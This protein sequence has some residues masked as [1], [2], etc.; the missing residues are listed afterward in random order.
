ME[1]QTQYM[2]RVQTIRTE[3]YSANQMASRDRKLDI[4]YKKLKEI[5]TKLLRKHWKLLRNM[6]NNLAQCLSTNNSRQNLHN[7]AAS[8]SNAH[9]TVIHYLQKQ[10][11]QM[12]T[13][14]HRGLLIGC[15]WRSCISQCPMNPMQIKAL[16]SLYMTMG[17]LHTDNAKVETLRAWRKFTQKHWIK[18]TTPE[19]YSPWQNKAEHEF[20]R[21]HIHAKLIM[22]STG[23]PERPWNYV[24][25][26][27]A[28]P[29]SH[30]TQVF[31]LAHTA[32]TPYR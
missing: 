27:G 30:G 15:P 13:P 19:P 8:V 28:H 17:Y 4:A 18:V 32:Q 5:Q 29:Q 22:D 9:Y 31:R 2:N 14:K 23:C 24:L 26:R 20:G 7:C 6:L 21:A 25:P 3:T 10:S 1:N 16:P 12:A 11:P